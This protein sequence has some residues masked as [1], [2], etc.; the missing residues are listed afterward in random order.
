M[1]ELHYPECQ[2]RLNFLGWKWNSVTRFSPKDK[3]EE[4]KQSQVVRCDLNN[5]IFSSFLSLTNSRGKNG[6]G[7]TSTGAVV[8]HQPLSSVKKKWY[9]RQVLTLSSSCLINDQQGQW[10][11]V[12]EGEREREEEEEE[13]DWNRVIVI[14]VIFIIYIVFI[15]MSSLLYRPSSSS[16]SSA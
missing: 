12:V 6:T 11:G 14:I 10:E 5:S 7:T 2:S 4:S 16:S 9:L 13:E 15:L 8:F 3:D 1:S